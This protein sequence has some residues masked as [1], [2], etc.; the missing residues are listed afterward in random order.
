MQPALNL[1]LGKSFTDFSHTVVYFEA[2]M[3][4]HNSRAH[5]EEDNT[6]TRKYVPILN[7]TDVEAQLFK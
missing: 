5:R 4:T 6:V 1:P 7:T 2:S 3:D